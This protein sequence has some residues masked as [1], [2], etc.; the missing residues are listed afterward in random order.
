MKE[1]EK[2]WIAPFITVLIF[3]LCF[4]IQFSISSAESETGTYPGFSTTY[5]GHTYKYY[6]IYEDSSTDA[7]TL[8]LADSI[9]YRGAILVI[10]GSARFFGYDS[11]D[12]NE[13]YHVSY[14]DTE[15][16]CTISKFLD[17][18]N[19]LYSN[20]DI[21]DTDGNVIFKKKLLPVALTVGKVQMYPR[22]MKMNLQTI[23]PIAVFCLAFLMALAIFSPNLVKKFLN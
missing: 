7:V 13:W 15:N 19:F 23:L 5:E 20:Y 9:S 10:D 4:F 14:S 3:S 21:I 18:H 1:K 17:S 12:N 16:G 2:K 8:V 6:L 11:S 22:T